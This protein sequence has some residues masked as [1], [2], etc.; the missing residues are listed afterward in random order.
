MEKIDFEVEFCPLNNI[1]ELGKLK[2]TIGGGGLWDN[3][4]YSCLRPGFQRIYQD[5]YLVFNAGYESFFDN[6][7]FY[8]CPLS[9]FYV[10]LNN[11]KMEVFPH[12]ITDAYLAQDNPVQLYNFEANLRLFDK[13]FG[14]YLDIHLEFKTKTNYILEWLCSLINI[15]NL[16]VNYGNSINNLEL[17]NFKKEINGSRKFSGDY[18]KSFA[19][20]KRKNLTSITPL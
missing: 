11:C 14:A 6:E 3:P 2:N 8:P 15:L 5:N 12:I 16:Y 18:A 17:K 13:K 9:I 19:N 10:Q 7:K 4:H 20:L 1:Y